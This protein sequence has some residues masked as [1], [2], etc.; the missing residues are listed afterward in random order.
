MHLD[1]AELLR[2]CVTV[3]TRRGVQLHKESATKEALPN[4]NAPSESLNSRM[5]T[6]NFVALLQRSAF[7]A[8]AA[9]LR[10]LTQKNRQK[11]DPS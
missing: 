8:N 5:R 4:G 11:R 7:D 2:E 3:A 1:F 10:E 6:Q 9:H